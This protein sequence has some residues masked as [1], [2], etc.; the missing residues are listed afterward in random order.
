MT[1]LLCGETLNSVSEI[2]LVMWVGLA[3]ALGIGAGG[4][5]RAPLGGGVAGGVSFSRRLNILVLPAASLLV[6]CLRERMA[7]GR[8][9][10]LTR[11]APGSGSALVAPS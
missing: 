9:R 11:P 7:G 1:L 6:E 10:G 5:L 8:T 2:G 3:N 4:A